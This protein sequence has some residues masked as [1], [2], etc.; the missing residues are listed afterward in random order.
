MNEIY[1]TKEGYQK[2]MEELEL[3]KTLRRRELSKAIAEARAHGDISENAEYDAAKEAQGL[4]E[5]RIADLE[6]KLVFKFLLKFC[7]MALLLMLIS[8]M[9]DGVST[10]PTLLVHIVFFIAAL[11]LLFAPEL[12]FKKSAIIQTLRSFWEDSARQQS[13][14][15]DQNCVSGWI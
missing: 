12:I 10:I 4:N 11:L 15:L 5:K 9:M 13:K 6:E 1:L 2:L 14:A 8:N 7:F 3:L